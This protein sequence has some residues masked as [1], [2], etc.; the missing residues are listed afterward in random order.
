MDHAPAVTE[1]DV[2]RMN[3]PKITVV[4]PSYNQAQFLE[5]TIL[6]VVGQQYPNLEYIIIDGGSTDGS[7]EVIRKYQEK[8][9]YW[10]S[11]P[12]NGQAHAIHKGFERA[13]GDILAWLNSDDFYLPGT[14]TFA[15]AQMD[16]TQAQLLF[17]N[18][19]HLYE[20]S[21]AVS[22]SSVR[23]EHAHRNLLLTDYIVQPSS[24]WTRLAMNQTGALDQTLHF[25]F[26]WEW[27]IRALQAGVKFIAEDKYLSVYRFHRDHKS[28]VGG[29]RRLQELAA[30]YE[31]HAGA[32]Y[33]RLFL[34]CCAARSRVVYCREK[35]RLMRLA[36]S[37]GVLL[38][39]LFPLLFRGF[40]S[41]EVADVVS[42]L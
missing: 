25:G 38:K 41:S 7:V 19:L 33:E 30:V 15:A 42:M 5:E 11:E 35:V 21:G 4:T 39:A 20:D 34:R 40:S 3:Y 17:G 37:E 12:D 10:V 9:A 1:R 14:L 27:F 16:P 13:S 26:D 8:I 31:R 6:S 23:R 18:C 32:R 29:K 24:F 22:G 36:E 28:G 2:K